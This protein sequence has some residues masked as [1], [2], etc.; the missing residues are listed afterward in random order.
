MY[1]EPQT[2]FVA[3]F[4]GVSNLMTVTVD[5]GE[6]RRCRVR[7]GEFSLRALG[8]ETGD[9][10]AKR[11]SSSGRSASASSR[12]SRPARTACRG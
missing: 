6:E 10:A 9:A 7:L 8:G 5:G 12:T 4:L 3:D 2:V 11:A 1:E